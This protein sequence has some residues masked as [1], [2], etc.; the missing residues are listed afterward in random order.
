MADIKA[1]D[2]AVAQSIAANDL[3]LGSSIAGTTANVTVETLGNHIN[4]N[5]TYSEISNKS[6]IQYLQNNSLK[7]SEK[8]LFYYNNF[9]AGVASELVKVPETITLTKHSIINVTYGWNDERPMFIGISPNATISSTLTFIDWEASELLRNYTNKIPTQLYLSTVLSPG[10][11]YVYIK[12]G[13]VSSNGSPIE[14]KKI[15]EFY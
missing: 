15:A 8:R 14:C 6:V 9:S 12:A 7:L 5:I 3:I 10:T 11:Y 4:K 1:K 13:N 2:I